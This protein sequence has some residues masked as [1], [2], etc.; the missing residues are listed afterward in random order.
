M[1]FSNNKDIYHGEF[2][3][4]TRSGECI[5]T[6]GNGDVYNGAWQNDRKHGYGKMTYS[7]RG[8]WH[9]KSFEGYWVEDKPDSGN[10]F[11]FN[12]DDGTRYIGDIEDGKRNGYG[13]LTAPDCKM[14][15][16]VKE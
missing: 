3:K 13:T 6:W 4:G 7:D 1:R 9:G 10:G 12:P 16:R 14:G 11:V 8:H 15:S 2:R 5:Y